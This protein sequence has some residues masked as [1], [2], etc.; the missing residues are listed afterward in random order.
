M[1]FEMRRRELPLLLLA[2][3]VCSSAIAETEVTIAES[4]SFPESTRRW[5]RGSTE[6]LARQ[7]DGWFGDKPFEEGGMISDGR[8]DIGLFKR[9]DENVDL[10]VRFNAHFRLPNVEQHA[11][12]FIGRDD[13]RDVIRDTPDELQRQQQLLAIRPVEHSLLAGLGVSLRDSID[14]R[15]GLGPG[16]KPYVQARFERP[17][18]IGDA[19]RMDFRETVFWTQEDRVGATSVLSYEQRF[20]PVL[21]LKWQLA[22][23]VTQAQKQWEWAGSVGTYR[24]FGGQRLLSLEAVTSGTGEEATPEVSSSDRGLLVRWEQPVH[25]DGLLAEF[26]VGHFWPH[27]DDARG[28]ERAWALGVSLKLR[29]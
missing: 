12:L 20:T 13:R 14:F 2:L 15:L 28:R 11:Y 16:L 8:L 4:S 7:V 9:Q 5:V 3:G 25:R 26:V 21:A 10:D 29:F 22:G 19:Q 23:T 6:W 18:I 24:S 17:W 27:F 1:R